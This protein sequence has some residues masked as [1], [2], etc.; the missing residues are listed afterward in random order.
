MTFEL[1]VYE[2]DCVIVGSGIAGLRAAEVVGPHA[3]TCVITKGKSKE[4]STQYAQGGIAVALNEDDAPSHHF[5]DTLAAGDGLCDP[6]AVR[7]LVEDGPRRVEELIGMGANFDKKNGDFDFTTEGA[8]RKRR[9]LHAGDATGREIEKALGRKLLLDGYVSF[10]EDTAVL[11][12][13]VQDKRCYGCI[14]IKAGKLAVFYAK[15]VILATGGYSQVYAYNTNP[16]LATGDGIALAY[17]AGC[18]VADMEFVQFHPTTLYLGDKKPI[19]IFLITEAVRGEGAI[20][21]NQNLER[22]MPRYHPD[23]ELAPRDIVSR[24]ILSEMQ[25]TKTDHVYLDLSGLTVDIPSRFPTIY[26]RCLESQIDIT[27]SFI[28]VA[29]A[30]HYCMGGV[31][32]DV[33]ARTTIDGL[34]AA[35]EVTSMGIHGANRLASNSLLDGLVFGYRAG[36]HVVD[37]LPGNAEPLDRA[38]PMRDRFVP[39]H[40]DRIK[41]MRIREELRSLM[42]HDVGIVREGDALEKVLNRLKGF[43]SAIAGFGFHEDVIEVQNM[44]L[45]S[46]LCAEFAFAR[47]E[48]RGAHFRVDF[49]VRDDVAWQLH[50]VGKASGAQLEKVPNI[51]KRPL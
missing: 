10:F 16:P 28:P 41:L 34:Y 19:S 6:E 35:G 9:I 5:E 15:S 18:E 38:L 37:S 47:Q 20:L 12:L 11:E 17:N 39:S 40:Q 30:A 23:A 22:F 25:N 2:F 50:L 1:S 3:R 48:S 8:H 21:L 7:V 51:A 32:T 14:A 36:R 27:K 26:K 49:P 44:L 4:S 29:P 33:W 43:E 45:V 24:A 42:W 46:R 13:L 31:C